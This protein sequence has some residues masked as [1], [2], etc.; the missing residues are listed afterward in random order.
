MLEPNV[1][2]YQGA[3]NP[4]NREIRQTLQSPDNKE[5][6]WLNNGITYL[7]HHVL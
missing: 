5:F 2:D 6:W 3:N 7:L 1:R 4:V